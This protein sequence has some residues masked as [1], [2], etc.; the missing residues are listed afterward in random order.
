V[1]RGIEGRG[2]EDEGAVVELREVAGALDEFA[3][4]GGAEFAV[5]VAIAFEE[6]AH[7]AG[8][9]GGAKGGG[10]A[11]EDAFVVFG[12]GFVEE[13]AVAGA[14]EEGG[15]GNFGDGQIGGDDEHELEGG[16]RSSGRCRG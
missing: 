7:E 12:G 2:I 14:A 4:F 10:V 5:F 16:L 15:I 9:N 6:L 13:E 3:G 11:V 8:G 1:P